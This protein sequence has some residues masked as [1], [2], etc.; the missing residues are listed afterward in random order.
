MDYIPTP[1]QNKSILI[2]FTSFI[3]PFGIFLL[4]LFSINY[5][6]ILRLDLAFPFL[7]FLPRQ[8]SVQ[9]KKQQYKYNNVSAK[10][11]FTDYL[12][13]NLRPEFV[14]S[15]FSLNYLKNSPEY[16]VS[17][18]GD[19]Y[20]VSGFFHFKTNSN[21]P[22]EAGFMVV[23]SS[24]QIAFQGATVDLAQNYINKYL[25]NIDSNPSYNCKTLRASSSLCEHFSSQKNGKHGYGIAVA[26]NGT[27]SAVLVFSCFIF[28]DEVN[29]K[30]KKTCIE[31]ANR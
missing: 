7:S 17:W 22:G 8:H 19:D 26:K 27:Q 25:T 30:D 11:I 12:K 21:M 2:L 4:F 23:P 28:K 16:N 1:S 18:N 9:T 31:F 6:N 24:P 29:F 15:P 13:S 10:N 3:L 20:M 5:F 14:K